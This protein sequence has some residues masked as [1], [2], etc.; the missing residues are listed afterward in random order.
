MWV[1]YSCTAALTPTAVALGNFDG[2]HLGHRQVVQ[3]ILNRS[4]RDNS[5]QISATVSAPQR[6]LGQPAP[7]NNEN[8]V[9]EPETTREF[10]PADSLVLAHRGKNSDVGLSQTR[11]E[12]KEIQGWDSD[13]G[14]RFYG[15][16]V[17]FDPHPQ[18]FFTGQ[19]KKLLT[20]L[21]E[22]IEL[23]E[24]IGVEQLV[25]LPFDR[26]LAALTAQEFVEEILVGQLQASRISVGMDFRFGRGR[27]GTAVDLQAIASSYGIDVT[28]VGLHT[29]GSG[30]RISSSVIRE[31][32][33]SGDIQRANQLL[34]RPYSLV[35]PIVRGQQLGRTIGFP[36]ANIQLPPS[37]FLPRFG[38]YAVRVSIEDGD[39]VFP[40]ESSSYK[41]EN[42]KSLMLGESL[43]V[44]LVNGVMNVGCRPTV[45]GQ[46][47]TVEVHLLDWSG[48]LYGKTL[49][50]SLVE[51][52]RPEQKFPSLEALKTQIQ[53]DC[54][55]ARSVLL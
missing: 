29:C 7:S 46:Q 36:T 51:F 37:K 26:E 44:S 25:L 42:P 32:L 20:P 45:D 14:V 3:P 54:D 43:D 1:T 27:T 28:L 16:V 17:T 40:D 10:D 38:V 12:D 49:S 4:I 33:A 41:W 15:T 23:L 13:G 48:D 50:V 55:V 19:A 30:E 52:L 53:A 39:G 35:G 8:L 22:K 47:P 6:A 21:A 11:T 34:G 31:S 2:F 5:G 24:A 18:E 9:F